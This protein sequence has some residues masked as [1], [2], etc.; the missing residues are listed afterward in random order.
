MSVRWA[1]AA[2]PAH[3]LA[4]LQLA[5]RAA[6]E[7]PDVPALQR[8]WAE[9]LDGAGQGEEALERLAEACRRFPG[10]EALH[11]ACASALMRMGRT[12]EALDRARLWL[13]AV[14]A[15]KLQFRLLIRAGR[16]E[17]LAEL[18]PAL[19]KADP[20]DPDLIEYRAS[21][22]RDAP[23]A[24]LQA[25]DEILES[26]PAATH[27]LYHKALALAR[28]GRSGAA[29]AVMGL[30]RFLRIVRLDPPAPYRDEERFRAELA[31]EIRENPT[32]H[33]DPAGHA[34]RRGR[35]TAA[36]PL[37]GDSAGAAL[38][39]GVRD[40]VSAYADGLTGDHP[41]VKARPLEAGLRSWALLFDSRGHQLLH[42]H[43]GA[44]LTGVYYVTA[45]EAA[46]RPG[47]LRIGSVP[48][49]LG[50]PA[51]WKVVD[52]EPV[53]GTLVLFPSFVPHETLPTGSD[54]TRISV[55]FDVAAE[56]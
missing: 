44:W 46:K 55:A 45:P 1:S 18:E 37:P 36:F 52:V 25:C 53:P 41:F 29:E 9:A 23:E 34:T 5:E 49:W 47:A 27:L 28:L 56:G 2:S 7:R 30:D 54:E 20:A 19:R 21:Q 12:E 16:T 42:H 24:L 32:L 39:E 50:R 40:E 8:V 4:I 26:H 14:W 33:S 13:P 11:S 38:L 48:A 17:R 15:Q 51:P 6:A 43:P 22:L 35:R 31:N 10:D 3:R